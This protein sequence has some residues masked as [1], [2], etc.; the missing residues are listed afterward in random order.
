MKNDELTGVFDS[1]VGGLSVLKELIPYGGHYLYFADTKNLPYGNKTKEQIID[2]TRNIINFFISRGVKKVITACNTSSALAYDTLNREF[3]SKIKIIPLIQTVAPKI[4]REGDIIGV[5]A[6]K[7][8]A[9]SLAYT[10]EIKKTNPNAIVYEI[11]CP[12]L[13]EI[14]ENGLYEDK[15]SVELVRGYLNLLLDRGC[16]KIVLGCTH[17]PYLM[18][19]LT[20]FAPESLFINPALY[21]T[22]I[23]ENNFYGGGA[24]VEYY[25]TGD[26]ETFRK[27]ASVFIN[28]K[29]NINKVETVPV[30]NSCA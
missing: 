1:G 19:V 8:T 26:I 30:L 3:G 20:K 9:S 2:F 7:G 24:K 11:G 22:N 27:N 14:V 4:A 21:M 18:P 15:E 13:V 16:G 12:G 10:N 25:V 17:Y 6:T 29:E 28:I 23:I 5:M